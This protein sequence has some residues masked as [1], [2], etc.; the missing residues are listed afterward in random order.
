MRRRIVVLVPDLV[1][2]LCH[3]VSPLF[4]HLSQDAFPAVETLQLCSLL[5]VH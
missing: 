1:L 3:S 5:I 4:T 2:H